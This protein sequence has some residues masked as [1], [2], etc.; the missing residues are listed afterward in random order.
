V[1]EAATAEAEAATAA[2]AA[3]TEL[4][5]RPR[6]PFV[7][8]LALDPSPLANLAASVSRL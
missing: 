4:F 6:T 8:L 3:A 7:A 2:A 1:A 5:A